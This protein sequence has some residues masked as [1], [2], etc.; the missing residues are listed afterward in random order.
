M[1]ST[2]NYINYV[3][4]KANNL[5]VVKS[6]YS[7]VFG[8]KFTDYGINYV[9]FEGSGIAGGFEKTDNTIINGAL[10]VIYNEDLNL[11]KAK[12]IEFGGE[13]KVDIFSFPGGSRFQFL[14]PSGNEIAV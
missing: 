11:A 8:W 6:F 4:F 12:V 10:I 9:A 13:I 7:K 14:D 5:E 3:E 2:N 1:K